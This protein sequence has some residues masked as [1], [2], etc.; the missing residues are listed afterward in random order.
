[1]TSAANALVAMLAIGLALSATRWRGPGRRL[2][3]AAAAV[4]CGVCVL[5]V[6]AWLLAPLELRFPRFAAAGGPVDGIIILGGSVSLRNENGVGAPEP[7]NAADRLFAA[8]ELARRF[9]AARVVVSGGPIGRD[10]WAEADSVSAYL[11][12]LGVDPGRLTLERESAN[13]FENAAYAAR[14]LHPTPQQRWLLVTSAFHMPRAIGAFRAA[15]FRTQ[16]VPTD[17]RSGQRIW[18]DGWSAAGGLGTF[19]LAAKEYFALAAYRVRGRT[20]ALFPGP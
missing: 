7:N 8:A 2:A 1:M 13:T 11:Q 10:G 15:G 18:P 3:I 5:P 16:A 6:G 14:L 20:D 4:L 9:P 19:D 12:A 17:W